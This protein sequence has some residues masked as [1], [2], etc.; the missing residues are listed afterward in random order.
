MAHGEKLVNKRNL[1][2]LRVLGLT[3]EPCDPEAW[4]WFF[5]NVGHERC[6]VINISG[7]TEVG[8][9][10]LA[11]VPILP[12]KPST[13][14]GPALGMD[15]EVFDES[16]RPIRGKAGEL[17]ARKPWPG[18][19]R[20]LWKDENGQ[21]YLETY[22]SKWPNV[23]F[24][25][26]YASI[27]PDGFWFLHGRS[28]DTIKVSGKRLGPAEVESVLMQ[29]PEVLEAAAIGAPD[30]V[31]G[32]ALICFVVLTKKV[33]NDAILKNELMERILVS[34]GKTFLPREIVFVSSLPKTASGKVVRKLIRENYLSRQAR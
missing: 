22:W 12:L 2:S 13:L 19:T 21:H 26:D 30:S 7:G 3:G 8:G 17:V 10:F 15:I 27:D 9:A 11:P 16:G 29:H 20:G 25:G 28:D 32:E 6:P 18:I 23:W 33:E 31:K 5:R 4:W 34:L 1:S 24:V 14:Q